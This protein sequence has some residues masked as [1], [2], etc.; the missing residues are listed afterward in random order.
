MQTWKDARGDLLLTPPDQILSCIFENIVD[1]KNANEIPVAAK[2][3][4]PLPSLHGNFM[5]S[6]SLFR[7]GKSK[8]L[9]PGKVVKRRMKL[10]MRFSSKLNSNLNLNFSSRRRLNWINLNIYECLLAFQAPF[11]RR[12]AFL[13]SFQ[14][15]QKRRKLKFSVQQMCHVVII[16]VLCIHPFKTTIFIKIQ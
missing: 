8:R 6:I 4:L 16:F 10:A 3:S 12:K 5:K 11:K 14:T 2:F 7:E 13:K 1:S 15:Y 9:H